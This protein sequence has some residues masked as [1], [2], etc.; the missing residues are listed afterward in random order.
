M[1]QE[2]L[3]KRV[4]Y[5]DPNNKTYSEYYDSILI[6]NRRLQEEISNELVKLYEGI[7]DGYSIATTGSDAR[8]EKGPQS[9]VEIILFTDNYCN[10]EDVV[11]KINHFVSRDGSA[12]IFQ[13][14]IEVKRTDSEMFYFIFQKDDGSEISISSPN[15]I[16]DSKI[17]FGNVYLFS[18]VKKKLATEFDVKK[19]QKIKDRLKDHLQVSNSGIQKYNSTTT[20]LHYDFEN[21]EVMYDPDKKLWSFKQ[22]PI[23]SLQYAIVR[24]VMRGVLDNFSNSNQLLNLPQN[25][26]EKLNYAEVSGYTKRSHSEI[27]DLTDSYKYFLWLYHK[28]QK[29]YRD[30]F[31]S[32]SFDVPEVKERL[33]SI[34]SIC[35]NALIEIN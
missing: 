34:D 13:R 5:V 29:S 2:S 18:Q 19:F 9:P 24:D 35:R 30:G 22:G 27:N 6:Y 20:L 21:S 25:T 1:N 15:R 31:S 32:M 11:S 3:E 8:L 16:L 7:S 28:S 10:C 26:I 17:L 14:N 12:K 4:K 23:R 33:K